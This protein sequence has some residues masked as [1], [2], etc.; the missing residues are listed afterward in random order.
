MNDIT[1]TILEL[2]CSTY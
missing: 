2:V 1:K